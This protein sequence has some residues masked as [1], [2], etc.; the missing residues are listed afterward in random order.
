MTKKVLI[1]FRKF[2][3]DLKRTRP[4]WLIQTLRSH[5]KRN[6]APSYL[7]SLFVSCCRGFP[8]YRRHLTRA[9]PRLA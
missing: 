9:L 5:F 8:C 4:N 2:Q 6:G 7:V 3:R 1:S